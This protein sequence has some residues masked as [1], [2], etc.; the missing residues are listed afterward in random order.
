MTDIQIAFI[1]CDATKWIPYEFL[2]D[3]DELVLDRCTWGQTQSYMKLVGPKYV[4]LLT[5]EPF[6]IANMDC[7]KVGTLKVLNAYADLASSIR[8]NDFLFLMETLVLG[9]GPYGIHLDLCVFFPGPRVVKAVYCTIALTCGPYIPQRKVVQSVCDVMSW[10][11]ENE[12]YVPDLVVHLWATAPIRDSK[13]I[14]KAIEMLKNDQKADSVRGV[15]KPAT[16][17]FRMWRRD[18]GKYLSYILD[19]EFPEWYKDR[20]DPQQGPR[21]SLPETVVQTEYLAVLRRENLVKGTYTGKNVLP[22]F[23]DPKNYAEI[24]E[25]KDV[26]EVER[27]MKRS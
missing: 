6:N 21:Q 27:L 5:I 22:F 8:T 20:V 19:K 24:N 4:N 11:K 26:E 13:D 1:L 14:D 25:Y 23:H 3:I 15:T 18:K 17:P 9:S 10:L 12:N 2:G 7:D 16:S